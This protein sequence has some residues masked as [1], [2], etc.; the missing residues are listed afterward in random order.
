MDLVLTVANYMKE[1]VDDEILT[2]IG[3]KLL[4]NN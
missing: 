1:N 4:E 3:F 2:D